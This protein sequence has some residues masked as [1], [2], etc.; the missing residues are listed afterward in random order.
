MPAQKYGAGMFL[1]HPIRSLEN[2]IF[3]GEL[4][5][6]ACSLVFLNPVRRLITTVTGAATACSTCNTI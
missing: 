4:L 3:H 2:A 6:A 1:R 5:E